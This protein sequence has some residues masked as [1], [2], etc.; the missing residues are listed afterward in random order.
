MNKLLLRTCL[1]D[2]VYFSAASF[3]TV[4]LTNFLYDHL[5]KTTG[6]ISISAAIIIVISIIIAL[7]MITVTDIILREHEKRK[8]K[9]KDRLLAVLLFIITSAAILGLL[10]LL[11]LVPV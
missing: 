10:S 11:F 2:A 1:G 8:I 7:F 3:I 4:W 6:S 9:L 5:K